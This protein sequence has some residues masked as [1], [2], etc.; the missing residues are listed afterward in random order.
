[1][2]SASSLRAVDMQGGA[3]RAPDPMARHRA[4]RRNYDLAMRDF[5]ERHRS[6]HWD[7]F[8]SSFRDDL[9]QPEKLRDFRGNALA[10]GMTSNRDAVTVGR[11]VSPREQARLAA[12]WTSLAALAGPE[13]ARGMVEARIGNPRCAT[14]DGMALN[15]ADLRLVYN[16]FRLRDL[17]P[18]GDPLIVEIG[19]GYGGLAAK[20]KRLWPQATVLIFDLPEASAIQHWY[21]SE[22][23][24]DVR[25][26]SYET[27]LA[28]SVAAIAAARPD[29][30]LLPGWCI[31][32]MAGN[33][34]DVVINTRSLM[35]MNSDT[36]AF[37]FEHL[38]RILRPGGLFYC[39]NRY[40]K[41]VDGKPNR[42]K[43]YPFDGRWLPVVSAPAW[44]QPWVHEIALTRTDTD[45]CGSLRRLLQDLPPYGWHDVGRHVAAALQAL[46]DLV[47]GSHRNVNPGLPGA[48]RNLLHRAE[49][50]AVKWLRDNTRMRKR[51]RRLTGRGS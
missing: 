16:A 41:P 1:M 8:K 11:P 44:D 32:D 30:A 19:G 42:L 5:P 24:P 4:M 36:V 14:L 49:R 33:S 25:I 9:L 15:H 10:A 17:L 6:H 29:F 7:H 43:D 21:L 45:T 22:C 34:A 18:A 31:E 28:E 50:R 48:I 46:R 35:E 37:Y 39:V 40:S 13:F 3:T 47:V 26:A 20:L 38:Q 23:F 2:S 51:L 27:A 12:S